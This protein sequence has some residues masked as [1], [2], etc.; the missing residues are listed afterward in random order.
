MSRLA[1]IFANGVGAV[2]RSGHN[3]RIGECHAG[4]VQSS[5][6]LVIAT[7]LYTKTT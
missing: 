1:G 3:M 5:A 7:E 2:G 4:A 6:K